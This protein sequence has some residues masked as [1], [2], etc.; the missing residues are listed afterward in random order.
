MSDEEENQGINALK[1]IA[2]FLNPQKY[3]K[4]SPE[5][6]DKYIR[7]AI[8]VFFN[9]Y[10]NPSILSDA[11]ERNEKIIPWLIVK[12][13]MTKTLQSKI[14][15]HFI[16]KYTPIWND[17]LSEPQK[18][19]DYLWE[20]PELRDILSKPETIKWINDNALELREFLKSYAFNEP[21][22]KIDPKYY[23]QADELMERIILLK[24][25]K[26]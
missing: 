8:K 24:N 5:E 1:K 13:Q 15:I 14:D 23:A 7:D 9:D 20:N 16:K 4:M 2:K 11:V 17:L 25:E 6:K 18:I 12:F 21:D 26:K 22:K 3:A 19:V 10:N